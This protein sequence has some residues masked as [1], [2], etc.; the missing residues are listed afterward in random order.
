MMMPATASQ[1]RVTRDARMACAPREP[2]RSSS[3]RVRLLAG[4]YGDVARS[5]LAEGACWWCKGCM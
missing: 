3:V 4:R 5:G 1:G 2:C